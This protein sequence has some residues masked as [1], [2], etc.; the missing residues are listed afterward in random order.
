MSQQPSHEN[1]GVRM[2]RD[3]LEDLPTFLCPDGFSIRFFEPGD[4]EAWV[5]L[6]RLADRYNTITPDLFRREFA[7]DTANLVR[8]M[9]FLLSP[10]DEVV[11]TSTAW[12]D[13]IDGYTD[14]GRIHWVAI[15]PDWQG[16][17]LSKPLLSA[18]L[19]VLRD[20]G[21]R[22]AYLMTSTPRIPAITLYL[23]FGFRPAIRTAEEQQAWQSV[24]PH[25][26][27]HH[28]DSVSASLQGWT[29]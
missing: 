23:N 10:K 27:P 13:D 7:G 22:S 16:R 29:A 24:L 5:A 20:L 6:Y 4:E 12:Y 28:R 15:H 9:Q 14:R 18:N 17:G 8:R 26:S 19:A 11:G 1:Q 21:H 25:L 2:E 3:G